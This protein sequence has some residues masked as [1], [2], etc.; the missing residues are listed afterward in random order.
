MATFLL[1]IDKA[2]GTAGSRGFEHW[3]LNLKVDE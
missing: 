3:Q 2:A 1:G